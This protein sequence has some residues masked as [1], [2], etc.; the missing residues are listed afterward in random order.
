MP[1]KVV[2]YDNNIYS[3]MWCVNRKSWAINLMFC[4]MDCKECKRSDWVTDLMSTQ[5][6]RIEDIN[7]LFSASVFFIILLAFKFL[8]ISS[9]FLHQVIQTIR[10]AD[11]DN[12]ANGRFSFYVPAEHPANPNFTLKDN[13]GKTLVSREVVKY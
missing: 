10:A 1:I 3:V 9:A 5:T 12:F 8:Y 7:T 2:D 4:V 11:L 6:V 13:G